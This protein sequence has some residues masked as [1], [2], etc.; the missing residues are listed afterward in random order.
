MTQTEPIT[1][2]EPYV[3]DPASISEAYVI[4]VA[5]QKGG[6]GK[7]TVS[8]NLAGA[9]ASRGYKVLVVD[10]DPQNSALLWAGNNQSETGFPAAVVNLAK[11]PT[12]HKEVT[13]HAKNY[14][15][16]IIDCP[17]AADSPV[18]VRVMPI[19]DLVLVP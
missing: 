5:N 3:I 16:I 11:S 15:F 8:M 9:L 19:S 12:I 18:S 13:K 6:S 17:P 7:T 10:A 14:H 1:I 2:P 4:T